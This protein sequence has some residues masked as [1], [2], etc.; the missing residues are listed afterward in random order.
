MVVEPSHNTS[1][2]RGSLTDRNADRTQTKLVDSDAVG[3]TCI[4]HIKRDTMGTHPKGEEG[5]FIGSDVE[6]KGCMVYSKR[7][8]KVITT[9]H[10]RIIDRSPIT[11]SIQAHE[12]NETENKDVRN[13]FNLL[14]IPIGEVIDETE[15][16]ADVDY[17]TLIRG[18]QVLPTQA[19]ASI[20]TRIAGC[21]AG[22]SQAPQEQGEAVDLIVSQ[23]DTVTTL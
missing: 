23:Q 17:E 2:S 3:K 13:V 21:R 12:T 8:R 22:S 18:V 15:D 14:T 10:V 1:Q 11:Y 16:T 7:S 19:S 6:R 5:I 20:T 9:Q 4:T